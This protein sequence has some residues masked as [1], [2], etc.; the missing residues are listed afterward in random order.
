VAA[1]SN[2][3]ATN[4]T[5]ARSHSSCRNDVS[6]M[7]GAMKKN[8]G[9]LFAVILLLAGVWAQT[10]TEDKV[11]GPVRQAFQVRFPDVK[12]VEWKI[13]GDKNYEAEFALKGVETTVKFDPA[14]AWRETEKQILSSEVPKAVREVLGQKFKSYKIIETQD[15]RLFDDPGLIYEIHL[16]DGKDIL[17][18]LLSADGKIVKQSMKPKKGDEGAEGPEISAG[19]QDSFAMDKC[20]FSS[21]GRNP[22]FILEPGYQL[23][24]EGKEGQK[25][26]RLEISV[27]NETKKVGS[28]ETRVVEEKETADGKLTEISRNYFAICSLTEDVFYF[29]E[30][31][32]IYKNGKV[33]SHEG[34][35]LAY[36]GNNRPGLLMPGA[37]K[38]GAKYY[39]EV[40]PGVAMDRAEV[41]SLTESLQTPAGLFKGCLK[42]LET[43]PL[44]SKST[45]YKI[46]ASGVGLIKDGDLLLTKINRILQK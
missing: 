22:F 5:A 24:L 13:A 23:V 6:L 34:S 3:K 14:G 40:A 7:G 31:V 11:P 16:D 46:Y 45:E 8:V 20:V 18:V 39:Q 28:V 25:A 17:K 32:D 35:W 33:V 15:L 4:D 29:G 36:Q 44:E 2:W 26:I 42:T 30:D 43:T 37:P 1:A 38:I 21:T 10:I 41:V 9:I 12:S 27:L 19:W